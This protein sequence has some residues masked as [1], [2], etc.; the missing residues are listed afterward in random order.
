MIM[1]NRFYAIDWS[2]RKG[3]AIYDGKKG[4]VIDRKSLLKKLA[5]ESTL[6]FKSSSKINSVSK[7]AGRQSTVTL[8]SK[9][10]IKPSAPIVILEQGCPLSLIYDILKIGCEVKVISNRATQD[11]RV[12]HIIE[13]SDETDARIIYDLANNGARLTPVSLDD[14]Q[15]QLVELYQRYKRYQKARVAMVNMRKAYIRQ[16]GDGVKSKGDVKSIGP[17]NN[18]S[19]AAEGEGE[20]I[21]S[22]KSTLSINSSPSD[23]TLPYN[24][25]IDTLKAAENSCLKKI[26]KLAPPVPRSLKIK[27]LG[28]RIW[29]GIFITA[30]PANFPTLS[31]YLR[32]CGLVNLDQ[33]DHKWNRHARMLYHMLAEEVM[34]Q[35]DEKFRPIYDKCK[36]DVTKK[37]PEYTKVHIHNAALNRTA[38]FLAKEIYC[39][40]RS[41]SS[42]AIQS[43]KKFQLRTLPSEVI[44]GE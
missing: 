10:V 18:P 11:Y 1:T 44:S 5:E 15:I 9:K 6:D 26:I 41:E 31:S 4:A 17:F 2:H 42:T 20:S 27:G 16:F 29:A 28:P 19:P 37:Y 23:G 7:G 25:A 12:E 32:Y 38:T 14:S 21:L 34:K 33:L 8:T 35:R 43:I 39:S 3:L 13:K 36:A 30:N 40:V 22:F 24:I